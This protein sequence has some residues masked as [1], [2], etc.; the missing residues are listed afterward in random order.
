MK[1]TFNYKE[2]E[3][4][5]NAL[6]AG[7]TAI[8]NAMKRELNRVTNRHFA[9]CIKNTDV[10]DSPDSPSLRNRWDR[11][12][13]VRTSSGYRTEVFNPLEYASYY[14]FGHRQIPGRVV[15]IELRPGA[16]KYGQTAKQ[17]KDGRWGIFIKLKAN[18][19][20]GKF[21]LTNSEKKAKA[22]MLMA[23]YNVLKV[24][25]EGLK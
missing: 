8:T 20:K 10:G 16:R 24:F 2:I 5:R 15:F 12:P 18:R 21:V 7:K 23:M 4:Y 13:V 14:E 9:R 6:K 11:T 25:E 22:E 3:E 17:Q 19:V 1:L